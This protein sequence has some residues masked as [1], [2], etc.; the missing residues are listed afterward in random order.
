MARFSLA[1]LG[2]ADAIPFDNDPASPGTALV[3]IVTP[4]AGHGPQLLKALSPPCDT[5]SYASNVQGCERMN[6]AGSRSTFGIR[7]GDLF[8][9][10]PA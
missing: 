9:R 10:P 8:P 3:R 6:M 1:V 7:S 5:V 4:E 2:I